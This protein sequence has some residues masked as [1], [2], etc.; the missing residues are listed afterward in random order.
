[1]FNPELITSSVKFFLLK[2]LGH[3]ILGN[4]IHFR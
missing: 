3:G 1:M 2:G 4:S